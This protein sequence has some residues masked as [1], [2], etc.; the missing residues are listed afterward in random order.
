M[1]NILRFI[2]GCKPGEAREREEKIAI[3]GAGPA[4]LAAAG[5]LRCRGFKV[6][7]YDKGEEPGGLLIYGIL[8]IHIDKKKV[9]EGIRELKELGVN[10]YQKVEVGKDVLLEDLIKNYSAVLIATGTWKTR[11]LGIPGSKLP[12]VLG[13]FEWI[14][15]YHKWK[16]GYSSVKPEIKSRVAVIGGGLTAVDAV[17]VSKWLGAKEIHVIY[18]RTREYAPAGVRGFKEMEEQGAIIHELLS[19]VEYI[20]G[21]SGRVAAVRAQ[22]MRL[23]KMP[24]ETRPR[25]E[26]IEGA[27]ETI[28]VDMVL[29]AVG[30]YPT[31]PSMIDKIGVRL[32]R[33]GT[34]D[35][36]EYKRTTREPVFAAGDVEHGASL[37][38]PAFKSGL[39]AAKAIEKYLNGEIGWRKD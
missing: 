6:D 33:N 4:G 2:I 21:S 30:L 26:P 34:I 9:R 16:Y 8:E 37:I 15:Q 7:V 27:Y 39:D 22:K 38:G 3:V 11:F 18:R 24:G 36:D 1:V 29:E 31:P 23:V 35:T 28:E 10:F 5:Y 20:A 12:G 19:P 32:R 14:I 13:A 17:Y 25:P